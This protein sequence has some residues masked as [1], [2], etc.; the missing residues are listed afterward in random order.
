[1]SVS[2]HQPDSS[3]LTGFE[4]RLL[5]ALVNLHQQHR[6]SPTIAEI[7][8]ALD[9]RSRGTVHRYLRSLEEKGFLHRQGRGWRNSALAP[10]A[11]EF[12]ESEIQARSAQLATQVP[13]D[14]HG[15]SVPLTENKVIPFKNTGRLSKVAEPD[16]DYRIP[17]LGKIAAGMPIE[18]ISN[19]D[20]LDLAGFFIG[21]GRFALRV[22][23]DSMMEAGILDGDTVI[24]K[25]QSTARTGDIVV[26]LIDEQEAT[27]KRLGSQSGNSVELIPENHTMTVMHYATSRVAIQGVVVGQLRSY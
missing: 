25:Q 6:Q 18:A 20:H 19:E 16:Q 26:A 12:V 11:I 4:R 7:A 9:V 15:G 10:E 21:P 17:F 27:L 13:A 3:T 22:T 24:V 8:H 1:M 2:S 5:L 14:T 23:G